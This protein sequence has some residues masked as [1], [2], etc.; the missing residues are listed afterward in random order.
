MNVSVAMPPANPKRVMRLPM[1]KY[2]FPWRSGNNFELVIDGQRFFPRMIQEIDGAQRFVLLEIYLFE[3]G[4]VANRFIASLSAAARRGVEVRMMLDDFGAR[5]LNRSDR[6][7]LEDSGV[8]LA[9]YNP[10]YIGKRL[11]NLARDHRKLLVIDGTTAFVGGA[12]IADVFD[13]PRSPE[14]RWRETVVMIGGPVIADWQTLFVE[15]WDHYTRETLGLPGPVTVPS[16]DGVLGRVT[17]VKG[18]SQ[19]GIKRDLLKH[20]KSAERRVWLSTAYFV[21]S[22]QFRRALRRAAR[23]GVDV[24]L[25]LPGAHIDHPAVR[26]AGRRFY[27]SLLRSGVRIFEYQPRFL[28]SKVSLCDFWASIG[29]SNLDRWNLRWNLEA[30]QAIDD[31]HFAEQ[32]R[33]MFEMDFVESVECNYQEWLHR[34]WRARI[35]ERLWGMVDRSLNGVGRGRP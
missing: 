32:V 10:L 26:L 28:H 19:Q 9:F 4:A 14:L 34:P 8:H 5:G 15:I 21:P 3:S 18:V 31:S 7:R 30:N 11:K 2:R 29:S 27:A 33:V 6:A 1:S 24:R 35:S 16:G 13:P 17:L 25:L 23:R 20:I 22:R 12:G